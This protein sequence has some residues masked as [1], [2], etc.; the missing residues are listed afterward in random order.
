M[1]YAQRGISPVRVGI[2]GSGESTLVGIPIKILSKALM[3]GESTD[4][5]VASG[6]IGGNQ[7]LDDI[8]ARIRE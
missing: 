2:A 6:P 1:E 7:F 5:Q 4:L 3:F 8:G